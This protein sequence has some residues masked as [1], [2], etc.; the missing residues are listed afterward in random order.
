VTCDD[1][2]ECTDNLCNPN[3]GCYYTPRDCNMDN[4]CYAYSCDIKTGCVERYLCRDDPCR[5]DKCTPGGCSYE[6]ACDDKNSCTNDWC[7]TT[8][9]NHCQYDVVKKV[10]CTD[11]NPCED[12]NDCHD[13]I[14]LCHL[15]YCNITRKVCESMPKIFPAP[16]VCMDNICDDTTGLPIQVPRNCSAKVNDNDP[17]VV[18]FC[19]ETLNDCTSRPYCPHYNCKDATCTVIDGIPTCSYSPR[20]C[21]NTDKCQTSTCNETSDKCENSA[22]QCSDGLICT[23]DD[24]DSQLGCLFPPLKCPGEDDGNPCILHFCNETVGCYNVTKCEDGIF[25]TKDVCNL[26][27]SCNFPAL[28]CDLD[29]TAPDKR[30]FIDACSEERHCYYTTANTAI[31]DVCGNCI[32]PNDT[33]EEMWNNS[34]LRTACVDSMAWPEYVAVLT[35]AAVAGIVIAAVVVGLIMAV[36]GFFGTKEL[37]KRAKA[38]TNQAAVN[39]PLYQ[40]SGR[41]MTNPA[42][43]GSD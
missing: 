26:D 25:C 38:A 23:K 5:V 30:C 6:S 14:D 33:V 42:Y 10:N 31:L 3:S 18:H 27:G 29:L 12:D 22:V 7:N 24:C 21:N 16:G 4:L 28:K 36:G 8:G 41:E 13:T 2:N 39:N 11:G 43:I 9:G 34:R 20:V 17:C 1:F 37:I 35:A 32:T 15:H 40:D 19:N